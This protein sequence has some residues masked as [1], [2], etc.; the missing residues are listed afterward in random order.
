[1]TTAIDSNVFVALWDKDDSLNSVAQAA[2]DAALSRGALVVSAPVFAALIAAPRRDEDFVDAFFKE[3]GI[4]VDW[5]LEESVWR[6]AGRAFQSHSGRRR[7]FRDSWPRRTLADFLIGAHALHHGF[8]LLSL[9][10][11]LYRAAFPRLRV[12]AL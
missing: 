8:A 6:A 12:I 10:T 3:T 7:T 11:R 4:F 9:D 2:M 1:M 5:N